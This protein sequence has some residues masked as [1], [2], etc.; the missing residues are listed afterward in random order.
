MPLK[1]FETDS[2]YHGS[3]VSFWKRDWISYLS[4]TVQVVEIDIN[5]DRVVSQRVRNCSM[6]DELL[7]Q[8]G[9]SR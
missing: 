6:C 9:E 2:K 1:A 8:F 7:H 4:Y 3:A 5:V